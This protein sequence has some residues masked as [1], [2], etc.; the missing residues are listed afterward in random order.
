MLGSELFG[1]VD[2]AFTGAKKG[3]NPGKFELADGGTVFLD[4][5]GE[6]PLDMQ[7]SLL[8]VLEEKAVTRIGDKRAI[9]VDVRI[10][11]ATNKNL[12]TEVERGNFRE[13]LYYRINVVNVELPSLRDRVED[14][15][16]LID[17]F[18][19]NLADRMAKPIN[20]ITADV[21]QICA[22]YD[23]PGNV[24]ELQNVIE[25]AVN[26]AEGDVFDSDLLPRRLQELSDASHQN[27]ETGD[28]KIYRKTTEQSAI[29]NCIDNCKGNM[30]LAA[31]QLGI[32]RSTL[33]R[34]LCEAG[35]K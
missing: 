8:R 10:I 20:N 11:A 32:S 26:L 22:Q 15:P 19:A 29:Q 14:I 6:M 21:Y 9:P 12:S 1:Y 34:K 2:G 13:D 17:H 30:T 33:Y 4:E 25:R 18:V 35:L 5:I 23:W 31:K 16:L 27:N 24:R 28:L 3:G 7:A